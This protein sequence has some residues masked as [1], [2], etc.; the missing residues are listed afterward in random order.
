M[1]ERRRDRQR[2]PGRGVRRS[3]PRPSARSATTACDAPPPDTVEGLLYAL[4]QERCLFDARRLA[5]A[6]ADAIPA[7]R[8]S[9]WFGY[10]PLD[11]AHLAGNDGIVFVKDCDP[12]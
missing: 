6:L 1:V 5:A 3:W 8:V 7:A 9:P 4:P 2:P 12:M 10:A 11:P